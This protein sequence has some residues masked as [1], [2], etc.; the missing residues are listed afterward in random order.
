MILPR[1]TVVNKGSLTVVNRARQRVGRPGPKIFDPKENLILNPEP[2]PHLKFSPETHPDGFLRSRVN[3]FFLSLIKES[4]CRV[5][6]IDKF[7]TDLYLWK[8]PEFLIFIVKA[9][10]STSSSKSMVKPTGFATVEYKECLTEFQ[11]GK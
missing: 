2:G 8:D 3:I 9:P 1:R 7:L 10:I 4:H 11:K 5:Y 6:L